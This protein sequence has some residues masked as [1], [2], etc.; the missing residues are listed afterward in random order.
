MK[1]HNLI[2][3]E[4]IQAALLK[5]KG[6]EARLTSFEIKDFTSKGD[7]FMCFV[8]SVEVHYSLEDQR[9]TTSF[10]VK[11]NPSTN[12]D[13]NNAFYVVNILFHEV[14]LSEVDTQ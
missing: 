7:G 14:S 13:T 1:E 8:T 5:S 11:L 3:E 4:Y 2:K 10:V 6:P 12:D 9:S